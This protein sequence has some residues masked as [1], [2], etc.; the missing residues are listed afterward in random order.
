MV[1]RNPNWFSHFPGLFPWEDHPD[2]FS[3]WGPKWKALWWLPA[4]PNV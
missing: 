2:G 4:I 1:A 3:F